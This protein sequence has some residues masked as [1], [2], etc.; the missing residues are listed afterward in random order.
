MNRLAQLGFL[1]NISA[2][3]KFIGGPLDGMYTRWHGQELPEYIETTS[4]SDTTHVPH[5]YQLWVFTDSK[6]VTHTT[7]K[8]RGRQSTT[9]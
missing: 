4:G 2:T 9:E 7:Y 3:I 8:H 5:L 1:P 6:G